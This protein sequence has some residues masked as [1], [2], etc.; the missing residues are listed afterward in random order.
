MKNR[1]SSM[2]KVLL[3]IIVILNITSCG[4]AG[5][6]IQSNYNDPMDEPATEEEGSD[7]GIDGS[8]GN[9]G[10]SDGDSDSGSD[11]ECASDSNLNA[12]NDDEDGP[13]LGI[14]PSDVSMDGVNSVRYFVTDDGLVIR[15]EDTTGDPNP[16]GGFNGGGTGN[17]ALLGLS[18]YDGKPVADL[19]K[20][21]LSARLDGGDS[22]FYLNMQIDCD[23]NDVWEPANDGIFVVDS[24]TLPAFHLTDDFQKIII[25]SA[26]PIFKRVGGAN[27]A[28]GDYP[29]HLDNVGKPL[30]V[31][32][33]E[34]KLFYGKTGDG[35]MPDD[36]DMPSIL[37]IMNDSGTNTQRIV[38]IKWVILNGIDE[39]VFSGNN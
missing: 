16:V 38:T 39:F 19:T 32:P 35:G 9:T 34:A 21:E 12:K 33:P 30:T 29:S 11:C 27:D 8:S 20:I 14:F 15:S 26:D 6:L 37:L 22:H 2:C 7:D 28:C 24:D 3:I 1:R 10:G 18:L 4:D 23:G 17:K 31:L 13:L 25:S 36:L 5:A